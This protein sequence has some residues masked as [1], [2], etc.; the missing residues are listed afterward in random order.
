M[1]GCRRLTYLERNGMSS[2]GV[3]PKSMGFSRTDLKKSFCTSRSPSD[4]FYPLD[5][6]LILPLKVS[7]SEPIPSDSPG[8]PSLIP[9][10]R[11]VK[12]NP[13]R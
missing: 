13:T 4:L 11:P 3:D 12:R 9:R 6:H 1:R 10:F 5:D 2:V 8:I 7:E